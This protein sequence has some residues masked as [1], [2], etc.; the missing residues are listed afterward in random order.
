MELKINWDEQLWG[1]SGK[2]EGAENCSNPRA[3][4]KN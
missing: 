3:G 4:Q 2:E 1:H